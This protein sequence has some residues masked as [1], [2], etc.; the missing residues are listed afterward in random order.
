MVHRLLTWLFWLAAS[1]IAGPGVAVT[2]DPG[3]DSSSG[4]D[5]RHPAVRGERLAVIAVAVAIAL[6]TGAPPAGVVIL[7]IIGIVI[8]LAAR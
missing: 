7:A 3:L 1:V 8:V 2:G 4:V 5:G 6:A